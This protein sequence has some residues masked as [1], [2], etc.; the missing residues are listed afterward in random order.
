MTQLQGNRGNRGNRGNVVSTP[1]A[2]TFAYRHMVICERRI[3]A[4]D[5]DIEIWEY[6]HRGVCAHI[7]KRMGRGES[8]RRGRFTH[9][10]GAAIT[11][12]ISTR[13]HQQI[14]V[15]IEKP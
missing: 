5:R 10:H 14:R 1:Y 12:Q 8:R 2:Q 3:S 15:V 4:G 13:S 11:T 9:A 7:P 6:V